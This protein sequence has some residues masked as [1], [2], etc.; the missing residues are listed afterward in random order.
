M[1]QL[2]N[3][4]NACNVLDSSLDACGTKSTTVIRC[5]LNIYVRVHLLL[6]VRVHLLLQQLCKSTPPFTF[7]QQQQHGMM[8]GHI[9][10]TR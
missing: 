10:M 2:I 5:Q 8:H 7:Q 4:S 3:Y 1:T 6:H 9:A